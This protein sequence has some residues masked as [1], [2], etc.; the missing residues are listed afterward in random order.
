MYGQL[1]ALEL[2]T[3]MHVVMVSPSLPV[4]LCS[5]QVHESTASSPHSIIQLKPNHWCHT[6][7]AFNLLQHSVAT[8][9]PR[10]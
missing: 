6:E 1:F 8:D 4:N 7:G 3:V 5:G 9:P 2:V 10:T